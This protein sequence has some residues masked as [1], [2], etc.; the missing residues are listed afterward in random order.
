MYD[1]FELAEPDKPFYPKRIDWEW[2][3]DACPCNA[4]ILL[5]PF[6]QYIMTPKGRVAVCSPCFLHINPKYKELGLKQLPE[7][8]ASLSDG[9]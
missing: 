4:K 2:Q 3:T 6:T 9:V 5:T 1:S 8:Y 7:W